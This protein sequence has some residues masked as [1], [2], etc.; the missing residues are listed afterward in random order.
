MIEEHID[1]YFGDF[2]E[3]NMDTNSDEEELDSEEFS[4][5]NE[6]EGLDLSSDDITNSSENM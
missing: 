6:N 4:N 1:K 2:L 5:L 3:F